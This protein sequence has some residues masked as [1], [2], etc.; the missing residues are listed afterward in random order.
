MPHR[1]R[2]PRA[3]THRGRCAPAVCVWIALALGCRGGEPLGETLHAVTDEPRSCTKDERLVTEVIDEIHQP[4][5]HCALDSDCPCGTRCNPDGRCFADCVSDTDPSYPCASGLTCDGWG[6]CTAPGAP[7]PPPAALPVLAVDRTTLTLDAPTAGGAWATTAIEVSLTASSADSAL[8]AEVVLS[9]SSAR[10]AGCAD[11]DPATACPAAGPSELEVA[12]AP[13]APFAPQCKLS[14]PW[15]YVGN[16]AMRTVF[17]RPRAAA[18]ATSWEVRLFSEQAAEVPQ[19]VT[20]ERRDPTPVPFAGSYSGMLELVDAGSATPLR[21]PVHA[22]ARNNAVLIDDRTRIVSP[23][24]RL[25]L[26]QYETVRTPWLSHSELVDVAVETY[27][28][29]L[30]SD[31]ALGTIDATFTVALPAWPDTRSGVPARA[32]MVWHVALKR[33]GELTGSACTS[34]TSCGTGAACDTVLATCIP[35]PSFTALN[36]VFNNIHAGALDGA[37]AIPATL[38]IG[39]TG[40]DPAERLQCYAAGLSPA[41]MELG[42]SVL[43]PSREI[44][45]ASGDAPQ[46]IRLPVLRDSKAP[47]GDRLLG[48]LFQTCLNDLAASPTDLTTRKCISLGRTYP[49]LA[50][51]ASSSLTQDRRAGL[52]L[53]HDVRDW[54]TVHAFVAGQARLQSAIGGGAAVDPSTILDRIATGI[55]VVLDPRVSGSLVSLPVGELARPDHRGA[56]QPISYWPSDGASATDVEGRANLGAT[57]AS[58]DESAASFP[59]ATFARDLTATFTAAVDVFRYFQ[60]SAISSPWLSIELEPRQGGLYEVG[61]MRA[62]GGQTG[63]WWRTTGFDMGGCIN[64]AIEQH[65]VAWSWDPAISKCW[66][67]S[68]LRERVAP[69]DGA[70]ASVRTGYLQAA[71][72]PPGATY[73]PIVED[74]F[75]RPGGD[76]ASYATPSW[77]TCQAAC[78]AQNG[79]LAWAFGKATAQCYLKGRNAQTTWVHKSVPLRVPNTAAISGLSADGARQQAFLSGQFADNTT[80]LG[81]DVAT[82]A[83]TTWEAC[84]DACRANA[85]CEAWVFQKGAQFCRLR[86]QITGAAAN[87]YNVSGWRG[88]IDLVLSHRG[89][90]GE[91][92]RVRTHLTDD[93][94]VTEGL[95][96]PTGFTVVRRVDQGSYTVYRRGAPPVTL[97]YGANAPFVPDAAALVV[98]RTAH[99]PVH[100]LAMFDTPLD[101]LE[102][103]AIEDRRRSGVLKPVLRGGAAI[104]SVTGG[105]QPI[106]LPVTLVETVEAEQ[107]LVASALDDHA[108]A[109]AAEC[110]AGGDTPT[111]DALLAR[112]GDVLR[113]DALAVALADELHERATL[114]GCRRDADCASTGAGATCGAP[115]AAR[116][117]ALAMTRSGTMTTCLA[118]WDADGTGICGANGTGSSVATAPGPGSAT[119]TFTVPKT[120][121]YRVWARVVAQ[122]AGS[123]S[124]WGRI[125]SGA[126]GAWE[127]GTYPEAGW[128]WRSVATTSLAAGSH[129]IAVSVREDGAVLRELVI[130]ADLRATP[131]GVEDNVCLDPQGA[132]L[133]V[134]TVWDAPY[135]ASRSAADATRAD[136][137]Q[138]LASASECKNPLGMEAGDLPLYFKDPV[139]ATSRYFAS[140]DY[141]MS[142]AQPALAS[143]TALYGEAHNAWVQQVNE[144][145][146]RDLSVSDGQHRVEQTAGVFEQPLADLCGTSLS[147]PGAL[148]SALSSGVL[149]PAACFVE[150]TPACAANFAGPIDQVAAGCYRGQLGEAVLAMQS[151]SLR[152]AAARQAWTAKQADYEKQSELCVFT[153]GT[154][155]MV[156]AHYDHLEQLRREKADWDWYASVV[157][158]VGGIALAVASAG[159]ATAVIAAA[160]TAQ[161]VA[162]ANAGE[163]S[164]QAG[165]IGSVLSGVLG[166]YGRALQAK[167]DAENAAYTAEVARRSAAQSVMECWARADATRDGIEAARLAL[168][169]AAADFEAAALRFGNLR[170]RSEALV[171]EGAVAV[172]REAGRAVERPQFDFWLAAATQ[173]FEHELAW[174]K[175]L[176]YMTLLAVEYEFQTKVALRAQILDARTPDALTTALNQLLQIQA[177][178]Q[179]NSSRPQQKFVVLSLAKD[180]LKLKG[181]SDEVAAQ[182]RELIRDQAQRITDESGSV[183]G[184]GIRFALTPDLVPALL[185]RCGERIWSTLGAIQTEQALSRRPHVRLLQSPTFSSQLCGST[186]ELQTAT[187]RPVRNLFTPASAVSFVA[188]PA[189]TRADIDLTINTTLTDLNHD[190]YAEGAVTDLAARGLYGSY[191]LVFPANEI[192]LDL[193]QLDD[194]DLRFDYLSV[195][196]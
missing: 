68:E 109:V 149:A 112:A 136:L 55:S 182:L 17:V 81:T 196:N 169:Q 133:H 30:S 78:A 65:A 12:C 105:D 117:D 148:L 179:V 58:P 79:C 95:S 98:S 184:V 72:D 4:P 47:D 18:L 56:D 183:I 96:A 83:N 57:A 52:L 13:N 59:A 172:Q 153:Q 124:L 61:S 142:L 44:S 97:G 174:A 161:E 118:V 84:V 151:A 91:V 6:Q 113:R 32:P 87:D 2:P 154:Q 166:G 19:V 51:L 143:A 123:D 11:A 7:P 64:Y 192:E 147:T 80:Y 155:D 181:T 31:P 40:A 50:V 144:I 89:A 145:F 82:L 177:A 163:T 160:V 170:R 175:R 63:S 111:R 188:S 10:P 92:V 37:G 29:A 34:T 69:F 134:A 60:Y 9:G 27:T 16:K 126:W 159:A 54:L 180:I 42:G 162:M 66:I 150:A 107:A 41:S 21:V 104:P 35:G 115:A 36:S 195:A 76:F 164:A 167:I 106:G 71:M 53:E 156:N 62:A 158:T 187:A 116:V 114:V 139:G 137:V 39:T 3:T 108:G 121:S 186:G 15:T 141:L 122:D 26:R 77:Q 86:G 135:R 28:P 20:L 102:A 194:V 178:Y 185:D 146:Q 189:N 5:L 48:S 8:Q 168:A 33:D 140:S 131:P 103:Q 45:C 99:T 110:A 190:G 119:A 74:N 25:R 138:R 125:D 43:E 22:F 23:T 38:G 130:T 49:A 67:F 176:T 88:G 120:G 191:V 171:R 75:D 73:P 193:N 14:P 85:A 94:H 128:V 100:D 127:L 24:G 93:L 173:R 70:S 157:T 152:V 129:T 132:R 101:A 46:A 165:V 90:T 1:P